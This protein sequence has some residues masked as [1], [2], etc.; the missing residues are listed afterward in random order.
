MERSAL[1]DITNDS[2]IVGLAMGCLKGGSF[3]SLAKKKMEEQGSPG[4][5]EALLRGQVKILLQKESQDE[6]PK[7]QSEIQD[8]ENSMKMKD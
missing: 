7:L 6:N 1:F 4:S 3:S 5:G 8:Q 2:P